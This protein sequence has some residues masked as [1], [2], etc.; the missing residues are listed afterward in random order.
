MIKHAIMQTFSDTRLVPRI[1]MLGWPILIAAIASVAWLMI[2]LLDKYIL[3]PELPFPPLSNIEFIGQTDGE[4]VVLRYSFDKTVDV[5][6]RTG[7]VN[8]AWIRSD[9]ATVPIGFFDNGGVS[10]VGVPASGTGASLSFG[11]ITVLVPDYIAI[12]TGLM[13]RW[14]WTYEYVPPRTQCHDT[15]YADFTLVGAH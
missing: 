8:A 12:D 15:S 13:L 14:C 5:T 6:L 11:P 4:S 10:V 2:A 3:N 9:G 1:A 7:G